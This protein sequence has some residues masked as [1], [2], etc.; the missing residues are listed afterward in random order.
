M[1]KYI[2]KNVEIDIKITEIIKL[3]NDTL[4]LNKLDPIELKYTLD[5]MT[6]EDVERYFK[7]L[8]G[9]L[10]ATLMDIRSSCIYISSM[11]KLEI[12]RVEEDESP[13]KSNKKKDNKKAKEDEDEEDEL[14]LEMPNE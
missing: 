4:K 11:N 6:S 14:E 7:Q 13:I 9:E 1:K 12:I 3:I 8:I 5:K 2:I 10:R